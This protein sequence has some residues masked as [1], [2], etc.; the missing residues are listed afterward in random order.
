M[1]LRRNVNRGVKSSETILPSPILG[2]NARDAISSMQPQYAITMDNYMPTETAVIIRSGYTKYAKLGELKT[3]VKTLAYYSKPNYEKFIALY[4]NKAYDITTKNFSE[5]DVSFTDSYCQT[6]QYKDRLFF[7]NGSDKPKVFY[8]DDELEEHFE[9]WGFTGATNDKTLISGAVSKEFLWFIEK[10]TLKVWYSAEAGNISGVLKSFDL[11]Q[12]SKKGGH[13]VAVAN[14]TVDGGQGIDDYTVF[15]TSQGEVLIYS[16]Y[17]P[18]SADNWELKG[19]Y[20][21]SK[22]IGYRCTMR[23]Q[24]DIVIIT[25]D[26]YIP[27]S[28]MLSY[29]NSGQSANVFSDT[30]R[31]LVIKRTSQNKDRKGWESIIYSKKGYAIF[32]VPVA[33]QFEQHVI[34]I[35]TGAWCR[36]TNIRS[37]CWCSYGDNIYF[38][39]DDTVYKFD[40]GYSDNGIEIE[41]KIEQAYN[42]F[43]T[44]ALKKVSLINPRTRCSTSYNL[45]IYTNVDFQESNVNYAT[46]IGELGESLWNQSYWSNIA[47]F[48][49]K[50]YKWQTSDATKVNSQ[51]VM[52]SA[53]G[54]SVSVVF[55]TKTR[56][57][58]IEWYDTEIRYETGSGII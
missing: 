48:I 38:G 10:N 36:F 4:N 58:K 24:G 17:N 29:N 14:W 19:S 51:W 44:P 46:N 7:L 41:G 54:T 27:M 35:N 50:D 47:E 22:P 55:K 49:D 9:D 53:V 45:T 18:N 33:N 34:N 3:G 20:N 11:S 21:I 2:L 6:V 43:G 1:L 26:G 39:S 15:I 32:N 12:I 8:I 16:G 42:N 37:F 23:Y 31:G 56:G 40:D 28:K 5:F 13:L 52:H 57:N 25:E 30:I